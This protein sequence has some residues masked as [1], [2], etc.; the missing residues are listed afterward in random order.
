MIPLSLDIIIEGHWIVRHRLNGAS[1]V[2]VDSAS[3]ECVFSNER[4]GDAMPGSVQGIK[5]SLMRAIDG[6][7]DVSF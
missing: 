1:N 4:W 6:S 7:G 2:A 5:D 3:V